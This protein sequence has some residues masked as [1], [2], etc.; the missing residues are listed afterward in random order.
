MNESK[1]VRKAAD[2]LVYIHSDTSV[3]SCAEYLVCITNTNI[4]TAEHPHV[5]DVISI[6]HKNILKQ[7]IYQI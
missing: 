1:G 6:R 4:Q 3:R 7:D 5:Y 2:A